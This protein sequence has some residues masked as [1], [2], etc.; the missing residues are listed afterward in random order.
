MHDCGV[1]GSR[2]LLV[3]SRGEARKLVVDQH[4]LTSKYWQLKSIP[5]EAC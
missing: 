4:N 1:V 3:A 2:L 5:M